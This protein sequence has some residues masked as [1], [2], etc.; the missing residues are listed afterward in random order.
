MCI[1]IFCKLFR[2]GNDDMSPQSEL[3]Q[4]MFAAYVEQQKQQGKAKISIRAFSRNMSRS[5]IRSRCD[6]SNITV[7]AIKERRAKKK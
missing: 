2:K 4:K 1:S 3:S 6:V 7:N 5:C